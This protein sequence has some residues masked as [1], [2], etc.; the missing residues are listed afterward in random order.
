MILDTTTQFAT[1]SL[2]AGKIYAADYALPTPTVMTTAIGDMELAFTDAAGRSLPDFTELGAGNIGGLTLAPGLYKWG[3][4]V[5]VPT[6]VTISG[7]AS[8]VWIFQIAQNLDL[9]A[10]TQVVLSGGA[11]ANNI[12]WQVAGETTLGT[13]SVLC[14][15]IL[16]QTAIV[17]NTGATLNGRA[18]SQT[19]VT[20]D[21]NAIT[22]PT[23]VLTVPADAAIG[24][25]VSGPKTASFSEAMDSTTITGSSFTLVQGIVF[26]SGLVTYS[27]L[28]ASFMPSVDLAYGTAYTATITTMAKD[29]AG[30]ALAA[31]KVWTFT[32]GTVSAPSA[33]RDLV[34]ESGNAYVLLEWE[35]PTSAG[36]SPITGY[37]VLRGTSAVAIDTLVASTGAAVHSC[38]DTSANNGVTYYYTVKAVNA[39]GPGPA[40]DVAS[41][42]A[43]A[44]GGDNPDNT[45]L[46]AG[47]L[48]AIIAALA[49]LFL[50]MK[51]N[52]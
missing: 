37:N 47:V 4:G 35:T 31:N 17:L 23:V 8:D 11:Q 22:A 3:T 9:S 14:G 27:G 48:I 42:S 38:N 50:L 30:N 43:N 36:S 15:N 25:A 46:Y 13:T 52:K 7:S 6:D 49:I 24:V 33:P 5:T 32:T 40:S 28:T 39:V 18:L 29:L 21:A 26:I 12:F 51:R 19:A 34:A 16:C 44:G 10:A 20:L 1:S 41:A 2:V 45:R